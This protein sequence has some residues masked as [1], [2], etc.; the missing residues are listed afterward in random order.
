MVRQFSKKEKCDVCDGIGYRAVVGKFSDGDDV[1]VVRCVV[2][3]T[4]ADETTDEKKL[5][6]LLMELVNDMV[7][8]GEFLGSVT[9]YAYIL[10]ATAN[11]IKNQA[12]EIAELERKLA[13]LIN[14]SA[15]GS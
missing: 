6:E 1:R 11:I 10:T 12:K 3:N 15:K 13:F 2:C 7:K 5:P 9:D 14:E 8:A 4:G